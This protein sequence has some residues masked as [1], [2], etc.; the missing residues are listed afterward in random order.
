MY[1]YIG[2][3]T[4]HILCWVA[5][6]LPLRCPVPCNSFSHSLTCPPFPQQKIVKRMGLVEDHQGQ[7]EASSVNPEGG[8]SRWMKL[9]QRTRRAEWPN[10]CG[11][12][13]ALIEPIYWF[14][15][16][17][18]H[19]VFHIESINCKKDIELGCRA[20]WLYRFDSVDSVMNGESSRLKS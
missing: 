16:I 2:I 13:P 11:K 17:S 10:V 19:I 3:Y 5:N 18:Y 14:S 6:A 1:I 4:W 20:L 8:D 7:C 12:T 9:S 15:F